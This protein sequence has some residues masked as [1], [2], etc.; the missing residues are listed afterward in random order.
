[1]QA[2]GILDHL[3]VGTAF[4]VALA[5]TWPGLVAHAD[6]DLAP[7]SHALTGLAEP[8]AQKPGGDS[9]AASDPALVAKAYDAQRERMQRL[10]QAMQAE[11]DGEFRALDG[12]GYGYFPERN[13]ALEL[14]RLQREAALEAGS[15]APKTE[16]RR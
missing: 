8:A 9:C 13:S 16:E 11:G 14:A 2:R 12:R 15:E 3:A 5:L 7:P 10:A 4:A 6:S 1:M